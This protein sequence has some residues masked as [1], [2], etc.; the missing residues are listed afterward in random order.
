[1]ARVAKTARDY[2]GDMVRYHEAMIAHYEA[3]LVRER[4]LLVSQLLK[5]NDQKITQLVPSIP[6]EPV[7][8]SMFHEMPGSSALW[9][10]QTT[11]Y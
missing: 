2:A 8:P 10:V 4:A 5:L 9:Q 7:R 11:P 6:K 3:M 1:M